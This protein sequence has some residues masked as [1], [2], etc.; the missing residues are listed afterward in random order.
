[1]K[2]LKGE[3]PDIELKKNDKLYIPSINELKTD[4]TVTLS[5][6]V[7]RPGSFPYVHNMV[8]EELIL[9]AGGLLESASSARIDV[10]RIIKD[11][12]SIS[13][14][15]IKSQTYSFSLEKGLIISGDKNFVLKPFDNVVVRKSPSYET[16]QN[17]TITG[18]VLFGGSYPKI[19]QNERLSSFVKRAGGL[20]STAYL[21]GAI[22]TRIMTA[23]EKVAAE[24]SLR[25]SNKSGTD[26]I[27][28]DNIDASATYKVSI[29]L[30]KALEKPG[31]DY[32]VVLKEGDLLAIPNFNSI[33]KISGAVM[34]PNAMTYIA[35]M[36]IK[37]YINNSGGYSFGARKNKIYVVYMNGRVSKGLSSKIEPGCEIIVPVKPQGKS[38]F[39]TGEIMGITTSLVSIMS[40]IMLI[41]KN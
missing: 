17:I 6:E 32:D 19:T 37:S 13:E 26:S 34:Y 11:P 8:I 24:A 25:L 15:E 7:K 36:S 23:E 27:L 20:K 16:Q 12:M 9:Q 31:S 14:S 29:E 38:K 35:G 10:S 28:I 18:E 39:T 1:S 21:N 5:G 30:E 4:F 2:L 3:V 40:M 33:V 22:L 41:I